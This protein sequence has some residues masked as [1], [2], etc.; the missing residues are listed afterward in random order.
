MRTHLYTTL[1]K[2]PQYDSVNRLLDQT[3]D[4]YI[5]Y[6]YLDEVFP[7]MS[8]NEINIDSNYFKNNSITPNEVLSKEEL[9]TA[10]YLAPFYKEKVKY[11]VK[12]VYRYLN[13][14]GHDEQRDDV[15]ILCLDRRYEYNTVLDN[16][17]SFEEYLLLEESQPY[18]ILFEFTAGSVGYID[19]FD[20]G[21]DYIGMR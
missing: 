8:V 17:I 4:E 15:Q 12:E 9:K 5:R 20:I 6:D 10:S 1:K 13:F 14:L 21:I 19:G 18:D 11:N 2:N 16:Y 7:I 3:I